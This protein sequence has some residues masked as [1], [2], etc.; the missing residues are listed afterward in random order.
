MYN[1]LWCDLFLLFERTAMKTISED[2]GEKR[3][4]KEMKDD[5]GTYFSLVDAEGVFFWDHRTLERANGD[6]PGHDFLKS[7]DKVIAPFGLEVV[8][9]KF[10]G[11]GLP[12]LIVKRENQ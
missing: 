12:W 2:D 3:Y 9:I 6:D 10:D 11:D 5:C 7:L 8:K 4:G 1:Q